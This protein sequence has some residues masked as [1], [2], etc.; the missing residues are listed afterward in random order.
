M[1]FTLVLTV[2]IVTFTQ[3]EEMVGLAWVRGPRRWSDYG[4]QLMRTALWL[5][6]PV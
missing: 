6:P 3:L 1:P 4:H 5:L 2:L